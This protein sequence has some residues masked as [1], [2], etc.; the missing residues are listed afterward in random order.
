MAD[1]H[2]GYVSLPPGPDGAQSL[3][4]MREDPLRFVTEMAAWGD[5][6]RHEAEGAP[7]YMLHRPDL[8]R[9][10][11]KDNGANYTKDRTPDDDM[12]RPLLGNGLL[13]SG[14]EEWARQRKMIA[15]AFRPT[16]VER[17]DQI[18]TDAAAHLAERWRRAGE[19]GEAV[20]VD[21]DLTALTL[22]VI[23]RA[24]LGADIAGVGD[25]FGRAVD[26]VNRF[27]GHFD[28]ASEGGGREGFRRAKAFLDAVTRTIV[29]ARRA[30]GQ[31]NDDLLGAMLASGHAMTATDL[32]DQ[33]LTIVMAGHETTAKA[34]TWTLYLLDRHPDAARAVRAEVDEVLGGDRT[35]TAADLPRLT[36]CQRAIKEA[37]RLYPPVW[38]ISRR[39]VE[40]DMVGGYAIPPGTLVCVSPYVLHRDPRYW[41]DP[42]TYAPDRFAAEHTHAGH[43]YLPFGGGPRVCVGRHF[44]L[45]EATLVLAVLLRA[46]RP[47]LVPGFPVE[48]EALVTLRPRHG[49]LMVPRP[50]ET[51]PRE[52]EP[53]ET[54]LRDAR[55]RP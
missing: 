18:M 10:V 5:V 2:S 39:S 53:R 33:V 15:P 45:V 30:T 11:L 8:A 9:H 25:G 38:L 34:L 26:E 12:L 49:M 47:E 54:E 50:R 22:T 55:R 16:E 46:V 52:T 37:M 20:R 23:A 48:P 40:A 41:P 19:N 6:T 4:S 32:R 44:A 13:T 51:E 3:R 27:I 14:G 7:V 1:T 24:M 31:E 29:A 28:P 21:H 36:A 17:F 35:P 43:Q 42:E